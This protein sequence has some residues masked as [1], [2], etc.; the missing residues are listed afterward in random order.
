MPVMESDNGRIYLCSDYEIY[1]QTLDGGDLSATVE[2]MSGFSAD[3]L[4]V[5]ETTRDGMDRY[6]FVW[7]SAGEGGDRLGRGV[8]LDDGS[9]HYT[10]AV[11]R[12]ADTEADRQ[13]S[14]DAVFS[15]FCVSDGAQDQY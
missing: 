8:I 3:A 2:A 12:S 13:I 6:E 4:T 10:M 1:I 5:M 15:S 14:W 7:A 9:Y 11:L